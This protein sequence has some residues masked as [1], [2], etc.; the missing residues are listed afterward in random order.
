MQQLGLSRDDILFIGD[1]LDEGGNDYPVRAMGVPCVAVSRW[2]ETAAYLERLLAQPRW[3][4][5]AHLAAER[6][7]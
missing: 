1:R 6:A 7:R 4:T 2:E 3:P 5:A